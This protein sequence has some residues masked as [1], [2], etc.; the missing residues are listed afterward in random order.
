M[1]GQCGS[2]P[3][4][5]VYKARGCGALK[6]QAAHTHTH[7]LHPEQPTRAGMSPCPH[8]PTAWVQTGSAAGGR[9]VSPLPFAP[10]EVMMPWRGAMVFYPAELAPLLRG[11]V[12]D[13]DVQHSPLESREL[14]V[15]YIQP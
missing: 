14:H 13:R 2:A 5:L 9:V 6:V 8:V 7:H 3:A 4:T 12:G 11:G 1:Q 15:Y 10:Q